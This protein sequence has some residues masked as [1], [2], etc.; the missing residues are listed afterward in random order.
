MRERFLWLDFEDLLVGL[1]EISRHERID[2]RVETARVNIEGR[3]NE[4]MDH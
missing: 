1:A 3:K 2:D 4:K